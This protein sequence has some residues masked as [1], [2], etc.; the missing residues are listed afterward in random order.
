MLYTYCLLS[1]AKGNLSLPSGFKGDLR[2]VE[3]RAIAAVVEPELPREE[4]EEDDETLVQAVIHHDWVICEIFR[5]HAVLPL[6]FG[7]YFPTEADLQ[8]HLATNREKYQQT[9]EN[10]SGKLEVTLKLTPIPFPE[11]ETSAAKG[12]AYLRA[13]KQRYQEQ[14]QYQAQQKIALEQ[15]EQT[16]NQTYSQWVHGEPKESTERFY[17][18]LDAATF[19]SFSEQIKQWENWLPTWTIEVS[20]PLPPYHFLS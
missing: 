13:K 7:T 12:K 9:L 5:D 2:L 18:L 3:D 10:L 15:F 1:D 14:S 6:R 4:L 11:Q 20:P 16:I 8:T 17:L 19:S